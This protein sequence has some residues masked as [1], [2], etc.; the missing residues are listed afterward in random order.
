MGYTTT[1][2]GHF[3]VVPPVNAAAVERINAIGKTDPWQYTD[4]SIYHS[5]WY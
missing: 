4:E 5:S 2:S 1:F 3:N